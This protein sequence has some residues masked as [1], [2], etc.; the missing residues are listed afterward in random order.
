M[1][2][3]AWKWIAPRRW[4]SPTFTIRSFTRR[5]SSAWLIPITA[6]SSLGR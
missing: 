2:M 6:A 5:P 3:I 4:Y 1:R